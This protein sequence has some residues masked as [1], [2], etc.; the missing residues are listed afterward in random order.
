MITGSANTQTEM[1]ILNARQRRQYEQFLVELDNLHQAAPFAKPR[2]HMQ[3]FRLSGELM[4]S[5]E[6]LEIV[7]GKISDLTNAGIFHGGPWE[8]PANLLPH[9]VRYGLLGETIYPIVESLSELRMI[10]IATGKL[11]DPRINRSE[12]K[13]FLR[14]VCV[15]NLD[16]LFLQETE[17]SRLRPKLYKRAN[18]LFRL[19]SSTI[20]L[21]GIATNLVEEITLLCAQRPIRTRRAE[22]LIKLAEELPDEKMDESVLSSI[23]KLKKSVYYVSEASE[24]AGD[25]DYYSLLS[26]MSSD[27]LQKEAEIFATS[28]LNSGISSPLH[29]LLLNFLASNNYNLI[30]VALGLNE[31]GIADF[32]L[33]TDFVRQLIKNAVT[34]E[35]ANSVLGLHG[36]LNRGLLS[37]S[38][39][40]GGLSRLI[41][42]E[43]TKESEERILVFRPFAPKSSTRTIL[44]S[45]TICALGL[46]LGIGQGNNP[47]CQ[48]ARGLSLWSLHAP[49]LLL[50]MILTAARDGEVMLNFETQK[51]ISKEPLQGLYGN[52]LDLDIDPVSAL[53]VPHLDS[54]YA[55]LMS[56]AAARYDDPHKWV[57]PAMYGRWVPGEFISTF[58]LSTQ[59]VF[60]HNEFIRRFY[61]THHPEFN[62]NLEMIYPNP[63]GLI[64]TDVHGQMLGLHA[65]TLLRIAHSPQGELRAYFYNP[66][67]E[68]RQRWGQE[69]APTVSGHGEVPGE[70]SLPIHQF[71]SRLYAFH[72][73][74]HEVGDEKSVPDSIVNS[75][76]RMAKESWG[77]SCVW[78]DG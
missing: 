65:V 52:Q 26:K 8:N 49:G 68:G 15:Q 63:V 77:K 29:A 51:L 57:N 43:L 7:L 1:E 70:S 56:A 58:S 47:T 10:A 62:G 31:F 54:L 34:T 71:A 53:L 61:S 14:E 23:E 73:D 76:S 27:D 3:I 12:A 9:L 69:I 72:Y 48:S 17:E 67:N 16:L 6:G 30:P 74:K 64:I 46:P 40:R 66:N 60:Q 78:L 5:E 2:Y 22:R 19:I 20:S 4:E 45:G 11:D 55:Q 33:N 25:A 41:R 39:V 13:N 42:V 35:T 44:I 28:L 32:S 37:R 38:E 24:K 21:S 50:R 75:I 18:R 59:K 36:L